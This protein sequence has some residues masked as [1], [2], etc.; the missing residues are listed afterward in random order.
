M[1][2]SDTLIV[3]SLISLILF[4]LEFLNTLD[5]MRK[6]NEILKPRHYL[7][8]IFKGGIVMIGCLVLTWMTARYLFSD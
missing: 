5:R 7:Q 3:L 8:V 6:R 1:I 4:F 2:G